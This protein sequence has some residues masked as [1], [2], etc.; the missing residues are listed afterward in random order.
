MSLKKRIKVETTYT[1]RCSYC[2]TE[3]VSSSVLSLADA[4]AFFEVSGWQ[5]H[6]RS[7]L[8]VLCWRCAAYY[9]DFVEL[10]LDIEKDIP[11]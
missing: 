6:P 3:T 2:G 4:A 8:S 9:P 11:F 10:D 5:P 1:L 7:V